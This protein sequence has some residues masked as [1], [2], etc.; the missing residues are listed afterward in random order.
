MPFF[1][2]SLDDRSFNDLVDE[3]IA[4]IPAHTPEWTNPR[5]G[6]PGRTMIELFAWLA[7]TILYRA[8]LIPER[9][10]LAFLRLLGI[11]MRPAI[12][13]RG[14]ISLA[15]DND[16]LTSA[17]SIRPLALVQKPLPFET[18]SE[19]T[20]LPVTA[21]AYYKRDLTDDEKA[22]M[23][24]IITGLK[25]IYGL[26]TA[27]PYAT[28]PVFPGGAA[29]YNGF[30]VM[31]A[32]DRSLWL[33]LL[34]PKPELRGLVR[35]ALGTNPT[36]GQQLINIGIMP[37]INMPE[38]DDEVGPRAR[39][40]HVWE[41]TGVDAL[42]R[43]EYY[44]LNPVMDT[45]MG[46]TQRGIVRLAL[47]ASD[48]IA[49]PSNDVR[50]NFRAGV[51]D[52]P[53]RLDSPEKADRLVAWLRLRPTEDL[54]SLSLS[55]VDIN[56]V[57]IDQRQTIVARVVGQ[58]DGS[59]GQMMALPAAAVD[60]DTL[61][62][63]VEEIGHGYQLW[64]RVDDLALAGRD[65]AAYKLDSEAGTITFGDGIRGRIPTTGARVRVAF[66]R[67]GGGSAGNL[68][69]GSL[70]EISAS[71]TL[72]G[73]VPK[74]K[75]KQM[76]PTDGGEDAETL[77]EAEQRVPLIFR[78]R[79]R[80]VTAED[81][82]RIAADT[83]G[84]R[85]GRVEV[86]P[87]F[88]P[89]QQRTNVPGVVSVM[90]LPYKDGFAPPYPRADRPTLEAVHAYLDSRR[91]L[92]TEMYVI[93]CEYIPIGISVGVTI[94]GEADVDSDRIV[95]VGANMLGRDAV[96][97]NIREAL[98]QFLWPL[99]PGGVAGTGWTLGRT[100]RDRELEV[101]VARVPGVDTVQR[102]NLFTRENDDWRMMPRITPDSTVEITLR[103]WQL[104]ELLS[105]V[106]VEGAAP[107][108]LRGVP[109]PFADASAIAV[110]VIP[111]VC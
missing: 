53:P 65:D 3:L 94:L 42:G 67:A 91:P 58:S 88:K 27:K 85:L 51:G 70:A 74:L 80:A 44:T 15:Y 38:W 71:A 43:F 111:K 92:T 109:N 1:P 79:N 56:A 106:V 73:A 62:L 66:M 78:H 8:N 83:P 96:L 99:P 31:T 11:P 69:P 81:Y 104:P 87:R 16:E 9:Q 57:E 64:T 26:T 101:V 52:L 41:I 29:D 90:V 25:S 7:D 110:P 108:D 60:P 75:V 76:L 105:V 36:G 93:G 24:D 35:Q 46:L 4:R 37:N 68:P 17:T 103:D 21:E 18:L 82:Q 32:V 5:E 22:D 55:W 49:A 61:Q 63:Q 13:A 12:P 100:V 45:T 30:D 23:A 39:I 19:V 98:R 50:Q 48:F 86:L 34:A 89:H 47:P 6:D 33:A 10:R 72:G 95:P 97:L 20:V 14:I 102:V 28:T 77:A 84:V 54:T 107:E 59:S 40:P 2:P